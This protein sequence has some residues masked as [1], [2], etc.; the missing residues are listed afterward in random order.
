MILK[1]TLHCH[2]AWTDC[3]TGRFD[4]ERY[5]RDIQKLA[6]NAIAKGLQFVALTD[7][8]GKDP[9]GKI[10]RGTPY[11]REIYR[12]LVNQ[13]YGKPREDRYDIQVGE[14]ST[15]LTRKRDGEQVVFGRTLEILTEDCHVLVVGTSA[16]IEGNRPLEEVIDET[17]ASGGYAIADHPLYPYAFGKGMGEKNVRKF[18]ERGQL[19]AVEENAN[20]AWPL[21]LWGHYNKKAI[22]LGLMKKSNTKNIILTVVVII[23]ILYV[24]RKWKKRRARKKSESIR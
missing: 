4:I 17:Y 1:G 9:S 3:A 20:I 5:S 24:F 13:E 11:V 18:R 15:V 6:D 19:L 16:N 12:P 8:S 7:I 22:E 21:E 14:T 23:F 2:T 10:E